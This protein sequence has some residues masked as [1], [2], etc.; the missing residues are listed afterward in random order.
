MRC[1]RQSLLVVACAAAVQAQ[2][3]ITTIAGADRPFP[4]SSLSA[5][6]APLGQ[7]T[8]VAI[9]ALGNVYIADAGNNM[10]MRLSPGG[11]LM[12]VAGNGKGAF[13][14]D[15]GP[16]LK[17]SLHD[18]IG[19]AVDA[20]GNLYIADEF[21]HR[22]RKVAP[23]GTIT[24][25]AGTGTP[26][27]FGDGGL[28]VAAQLDDPFDVKTD[29]AGNLYI[30]DSNNQRV[31]VVSSAGVISTIAGNGTAAFSGDGGNATAAALNK[32]LG[33]A[34]DAAG[35]L[36][37]SDSVN[38]RVRKVAPDGKI[39]TVA[40]NGQ[41]GFAGDGGPAVQAELNGPSGLFVDRQGN[42]Y[43]ADVAN[44]R[45]RSIST[46]GIMN[47]VAGNGIQR[48]S[49]DGG[50]A[51]AASFDT[52]FDVAVDG[53]GNL[54]I[55]DTNSRRVRHVD[56]GGTITTAAGN[57]GPFAG[58]GGPATGAILN[59]PYGVALDGKGNVYLA[60]AYN[61]RIRKIASNGTISTVAGNGT[62]GFSG[63]GGP[64]LNAELNTPSGISLD[65]AGNIYIADTYNDRI[66]SVSTSGVITTIAGS[67]STPGY[68]GD[69]GPAVAAVLDAPRGV[70]VQGSNVFV[71]DS[72]NNRVR[73]I[74]PNGVITTV[75]GTGAADF[76]G[77]GGPAVQ[78]ALYNP[79]AVVLDAAGNLYIA[80]TLN[81]RVRK[82]NPAGTITTYAGSGVLGFSGNG[83]PATQAEFYDPRGLTVDAAGNLYIVD[84]FNCQVRKVTTD[85]SLATVAGNGNCQLSG[86]GG[87]ATS[88]SLNYPYGITTDGAGNFYIADT[89]NGRIREVLA[90]GTA[91]PFQAAP[92]NLS[93]TANSDG[94]VPSPQTISLS[95]LVPGLAYSSANQASW[96]NISPSSGSI[97]VSL[98]A[99]ANPAGL[100]PGTYKDTIVIAVPNATPSQATIPVTFTVGSAQ[101]PALS[102]DVTGLNFSAVQGAQPPS[103]QIHVS[104]S[105]SG[106]VTFTTGV[107]GS[108]GS[109]WLSV[110]PASAIVTPSS[111]ATLTVSLNTASL[112][113]GTYQG[114]IILATAT[115]TTT[116][117]VTLLM[118]APEAIILLSQTGL[119]FRAAIGGTPLPQT[120]AI[121][122]AASGSM[123]WSATATSL[124]SAG[125]WL[126]VSPSSGT[127]QGPQLGVSLVQVS[128][129][130]TGLS[131]GDYFGRI[132][133]TAAAS[134]T[135]QTVTVVLTVVQPGV[136]LE[137]DV[138]PIG[139]VFTGE[140]GGSPGS[141]DVLIGNPTAQANNFVSG[142]ISTTFTYL[143]SSAQLP[144][145]Q[146]QTL[147]V[148][149]DFTSLNPGPQ[150][151]GTITLQ[152]A[153][154]TARTISI[155]TVVT[156][157]SSGAVQATVRRQFGTSEGCTPTKLN[158][159]FTSLGDG[160]PVPVGY[161][162]TIQVGVVDDC[163][164]LLTSGSVQA[165]FSNG[166]PLLSLISLQNGSWVATWQV[167]HPSSTVQ[168]TVTAK[169]SASGLIGMGQS[170]IGQQGEPATL[171]MLS[172]AGL[173]SAAS[174]LQGP[175]APGDVML[176]RGSSLADG[177]TQ[178]TSI[179]LQ[180]QL[181][182]AAVA[183]GGKLAPLLYADS[184]EVLALVP[185]GL[186]AN[187][188]QQVLLQRDSS[189]SVA[190]GVNIS[191]SNPGLLTQNGTG[192]GQGLIYAVNGAA[193]T[194]VADASNPLKPGASVILY[195]TGLGAT[196]QNGNVVNPVSVAIG[197]L[198]AAVSYAGVALPQG[199]PPTGAP[200]LL[201]GLASSGLGGLYQIM[202]TI[203]QNV[204]NGTVPV[205][206]SS[207]GQSSQAG[208]T[209]AVSGGSVSPSITSV[210]TS[211]GFPNIAQNDWIEIKGSNL[212]PPSVGVMGMTWS[213]AP[214]FNSD[215]LPVQ[216][217]GVSVTVNGKP[218]FVYYIS[219]TQ[220]NV[221]TPLNGTTGQV[222]VVVTVA[223]VSS[224]PFTVT[225]GRVAPSFFL[226][227]PTRYIA[228]THADGTLVGP[229]SMSSPGYS[230]QPAQPGETI[231]LYGAGFG[232]PN[233]PLMN[234]SSEQIGTL[235][236]LPSVQIGGLPAVVSF[237]GVISPGLYQ[238]NVTVPST[239]AS[240]DGVVTCTYQG[241]STPASDLLAIRQ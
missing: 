20:A 236:S 155:R 167:G 197:G 183:I 96:L 44:N 56:L 131:P 93:F 67:G 163:G 166:D 212:A 240:G 39:A 78:A 171:P 233:S 43:I 99:S 157:D 210:D 153:D 79:E 190:V 103:G 60:D 82:V 72:V 141:Q 172:G 113:P 138:Q 46:R 95:S 100:A 199:Y 29:A 37:I 122:D 23:D 160:N 94:T 36:Y 118:T 130:T 146:P 3:V 35:Y 47:T 164:S 17:A 108:G 185:S 201:G 135:P 181:A 50:P 15:G 222:P 105:G 98:N 48:F 145:G 149:P 54:W 123:A 191:A 58:D 38:Q 101:P 71:A 239:A 68:S 92:A 89:A 238:L 116:I 206:V 237:A 28:A 182:G 174:L 51:L 195:C 162:V 55:A 234:G 196:D 207:A 218:A 177:A 175:F 10:V 150:K 120:F 104:N 170:S 102:V 106:S 12:A 6:Q 198:T 213:T 159:T 134:N 81:N 161:P 139:L 133:V 227:Y 65:N 148:Y 85:G 216:L 127:V 232:L 25:V 97:P 21:N 40:G 13:S 16:A 208:V 32:P 137:P 188:P 62:A 24:T 41:Q 80:D 235:P 156:P 226:F 70:V 228:A 152:F 186:Q 77:D 200:T 107:S 74:L 31:R 209:L 90:P 33:I 59:Y 179:P 34:L 11:T 117:P 1:T 26:G 192:T 224:A 42:V 219:T 69:G 230:F 57:G 110:S 132:D 87:P 220:I 91:I 231:V 229:A 4:S 5:L 49:G 211:G 144:P 194:T 178:A 128:V 63:D 184:N 168:I 9:D 143:P 7:T 158:V 154:G 45:I 215:M 19:V 129:N 189:L 136:I 205:I 140:A 187:T 61:N 126:S 22:I 241:L 121:L 203:P 217:G 52:P 165:S 169:S 214:S 147:R 114:S 75:A 119:S 66:R 83:G 53:T 202:A 173:V 204:G 18:P 180:D 30:A 76:G 84:A 109:S 221:L 14:G 73:E 193:A 124:S 111:P 88:A 125:S 86:D 142:Q 176:I 112:N 151:P 64:A 8:G 115:T 223:G 27:F 225:L 2:V